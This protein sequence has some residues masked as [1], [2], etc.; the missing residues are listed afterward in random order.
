MSSESSTELPRSWE[1]R[2]RAGA[3][4]PGPLRVHQVDIVAEGLRRGLARASGLVDRSLSVSALV[5]DLEANGGGR[6]IPLRSE[7]FDASRQHT[8][9]AP[10]ERVTYVS[11]QISR[12]NHFS[13][14]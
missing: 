13:R 3:S 10:V 11:C 2:C 6:G 8:A 9:P 14:L 12:A 1:S 5:A 4:I 7:S